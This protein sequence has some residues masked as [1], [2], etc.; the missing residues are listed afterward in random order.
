MAI[1]KRLYTVDDVWELQ[2]Q[3][4][5]Q[6][7]HFELFSGELIEMSPANLLHAW[8]ASKISRQLDKY[9]EERDLGATFVE[10]GFYPPNDRH[11]LLAPDVAFVSNERLPRPLPQTFVGL[12]PDLA[13][14]IM[15]P[16]NTVMELRKKAAIYLLNGSRLVWI[17]KPDQE[18]VEV[19]RNVEGGQI[20]VDFVGVEGS[21][22]GEDV[23]PG[24]EL[25]MR[26]L[27]PAAKS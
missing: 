19:C 8:L 23:L 22:S 27:F 9:S 17:V 1:Q 2:R 4:G 3:P 10:G 18:G 15:S 16:S 21:L 25:E 7:K 26:K 11:T 14:E 5:N 20:K 6:D 24:F 13:V 12:M